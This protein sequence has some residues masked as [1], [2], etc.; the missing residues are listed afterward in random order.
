MLNSQLLL[1][2]HCCRSFSRQGRS[3]K[4]DTS[5]RHR[6]LATDHS[7]SS[8][9]KTVG[10]LVLLHDGF[11][12]RAE[13]VGLQERSL[14]ALLVGRTDG[15]RSVRD[16]GPRHALDQSCPARPGCGTSAAG[17]INLRSVR[18]LGSLASCGASWSQEESVLRGEATVLGRYA[19]ESEG[20]HQRVVGALGV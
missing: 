10:S 15:V 7:S 1:G 19:G 20:S 12:R 14:V 4:T 6:W 3:V 11:V 18:S 5:L 2:L 16:G 17:E 8:F 13:G 9:L